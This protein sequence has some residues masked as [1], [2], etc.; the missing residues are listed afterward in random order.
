VPQTPFAEEATQTAAAPLPPPLPAEGPAEHAEPPADV[1]P[2]EA[3]RRAALEKADALIKRGLE[4]F[5]RGQ[6]EQVVTYPIPFTLVW[7][8]R[9]SVRQSRDALFP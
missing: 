6:P 4:V 1:D 9:E 7:I 5:N 2:S 3:E 8:P